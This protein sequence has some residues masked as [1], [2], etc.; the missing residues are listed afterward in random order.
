MLEEYSRSFTFGSVDAHKEGSRYWIKDKGPIVE[1]WAQWTPET[2]DEYKMIP[3][4]MILKSCFPWIQ[5]VKQSL[6]CFL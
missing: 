2:S 4:L 3:L 5:L 1:R 6:L